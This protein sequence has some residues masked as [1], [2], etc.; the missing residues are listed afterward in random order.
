[1]KPARGRGDGGMPDHVNIRSLIEEQQKELAM[2]KRACSSAVT[3]S[4]SS[5]SGRGIRNADEDKGGETQQDDRF[6][7]STPRS[8]SRKTE[9]TK[10]QEISRWNHEGARL[11]DGLG[12]LPPLPSKTP[13]SLSNLK[14]P[15]PSSTM[16]Y[17]TGGSSSS[18]GAHNASLRD[19]GKGDYKTHHPTLSASNAM[20]DAGP[21]QRLDHSVEYSLSRPGEGSDRRYSTLSHTLTSQSAG[22]NY[23]SIASTPLPTTTVATSASRL[24]EASQM[25]GG[26]HEGRKNFGLTARWRDPLVFTK[27][28][29]EEG[30]RAR[31]GDKSGTEVGARGT[32]GIMAKTGVKTHGTSLGEGAGVNKDPWSSASTLA[33][34]EQRLAGGSLSRQVSSGSYTA[35]SSTYTSFDASLLTPAATTTAGAV[36]APSPTFMLARGSDRAG[37]SDRKG[38]SGL[39]KSGGG[40][41]GD[42]F[43]VDTSQSATRGRGDF[44]SLKEAQTLADA[45]ASGSGNGGHHKSG[46]Y[47]LAT[48]IGPPSTKATDAAVTAAAITGDILAPPSS[49][50]DHGVDTDKH[51]ASSSYLDSS[52]MYPRVPHRAEP[53]AL[54]VEPG[55]NP[56]QRLNA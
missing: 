38:M 28:A 53:R 20:F 42:R 18:G 16:T 6:A 17:I 56:G 52:T 40:G 34:L 54:G 36:P 3:D 27:E 37:A 41:V 51:G 19:S 48:N 5:T 9:E 33:S 12:N 14:P 2:L 30:A 44:Q 22:P 24:G 11:F 8:G 39:D 13:S 29:N 7:A 31:L 10:H 45:L 43:H 26:E 46:S 32:V 50:L 15:P 1:M 49:L 21:T 55:V 23:S 25:Q 35:P 4:Y 47:T